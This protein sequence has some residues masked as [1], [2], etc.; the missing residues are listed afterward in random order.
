M[1]AAL[2]TDVDDATICL[3]DAF[4]SNKSLYSCADTTSS[5]DANGKNDARPVPAESL[6]IL[7][8]TARLM[9]PSNIYYH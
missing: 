1:R 9:A 5:I 6:E 8:I 3:R 4:W 7:N 2:E